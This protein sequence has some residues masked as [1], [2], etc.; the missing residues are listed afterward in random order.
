MRRS[1]FSHTLSYKLGINPKIIAF[2]DSQTIIILNVTLTIA[3][4]NSAKNLSWLDFQTGRDILNQMILDGITSLAV[5][6]L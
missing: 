5:Y 1:S 2:K 6:P 3:N 4:R